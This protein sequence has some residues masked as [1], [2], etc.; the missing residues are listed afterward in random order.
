MCTIQENGIQWFHIVIIGWVYTNRCGCSTGSWQSCCNSSSQWLQ[1]LN[2][3]MFMI[4][5]RTLSLYS[6]F[7]DLYNYC[8]DIYRLLYCKTNCVVLQKGYR[9]L[10]AAARKD[11]AKA[12]KLL[13]QKG[14]PPDVEA[15]VNIGTLQYVWFKKNN[16]DLFHK[17]KLWLSQK[18]LQCIMFD[19]LYIMY[20][21]FLMY[22]LFYK[23][24]LW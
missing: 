15:P 7:I 9:S 23:Q 1:G 12:A 5:F 17:C 18:I 13:L 22:I 20:Q 24:S 21:W 19:M 14:H 10:H 2:A 8:L 11:F 6:Y 4:L 16:I 3:L